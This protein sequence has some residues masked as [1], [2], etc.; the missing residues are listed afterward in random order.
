M[1][2]PDH[3][4]P[5][6]SHVRKKRVN[7]EH[8]PCRFP[9]PNPEGVTNAG[10]KTRQRTAGWSSSRLPLA[11]PV[12]D[13][14]LICG[15]GEGRGWGGGREGSHMDWRGKKGGEGAEKLTLDISHLN[16]AAII[17]HIT[18]KLSDAFDVLN[19]QRE[20]FLPQRVCVHESPPPPTSFFIGIISP[21]DEIPPLVGNGIDVNP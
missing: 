9:A 15:A 21:E 16:R 4:L 5:T 2:P 6:L 19:V 20:A 12:R 17:I 1:T 18:V 8:T 13:V 7:D 10:N 3:P 11:L 14:T